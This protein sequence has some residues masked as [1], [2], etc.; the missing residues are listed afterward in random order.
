MEL[1]SARRETEQGTPASCPHELH[2]GQISG[3]PPQD[4]LHGLLIV[5]LHMSLACQLSLR[6]A[7]FLGG[8]WCWRPSWPCVRL[9]NQVLKPSL[10][11][12]PG[13]AVPVP[14]LP[15]SPGEGVFGA[16]PLQKQVCN[17]LLEEVRAVGKSSR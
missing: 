8:V 3:E 7:C 17:G 6:A 5:Q 11:L 12:I 1:N 14:H 10:S 9:L 13:R 4:S 15:E 16:S 2:W